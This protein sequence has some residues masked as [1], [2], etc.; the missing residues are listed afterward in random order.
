MALPPFGR[1]S[2]AR[3]LV[4]QPDHALVMRGQSDHLD[5]LFRRLRHWHMLDGPLL[6]SIM[7]DHP[8]RLACLV[9]NLKHWHMLD[10]PLVYSFV[11]PIGP[12]RVSLP[13]LEALMHACS[14]VGCTRSC[15]TVLTSTVSSTEALVHCSTV[16]CGTRSCANNSTTSSAT[17]A[18]YS[19]SGGTGKTTTSRSW[20]GS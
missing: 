13:E 12:P 10:G 15:E 5:C 2:T 17:T 20:I 16:P 14:T 9:Q 3:V 7:R 8:D 19:F 18:I 11:E 1:R 4:D 6:H